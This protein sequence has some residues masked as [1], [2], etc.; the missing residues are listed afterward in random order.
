MH[1]RNHR[2]LLGVTGLTLITA[3][4]LPL[5]AGAADT[6]DK[7]EE[8]VVVGSRIRRDTFNSPSPVQVITRDDTAAAGFSST[9]D[10]LA[11]HRHHLRRL[12]DQQCVRRLRHRRWT[13]REYHFLRGLGASRTLVIINGRRVA[14]AGTRGA[15][16]SADLNV[17][18]SAMVDHIEV[19]R[20]GRILDLRFRRGSRRGERG[21]HE[22]TCATSP[23]RWSTRG[24]STTVA[25]KRVYRWSA[26]SPASAGSSPARPSFA[27]RSDLTL[28]QRDWTR[29]KPGPAARCGH[30]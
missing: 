8:I 30:R 11:V 7:L 13:R 6:D 20:D 9:T 26:A 22:E 5:G 1:E 3:S 27:D 18:P 4:V 10:V 16:G 12:A 28:G 23:P 21:D 24:R 25:R 2:R 15:V 29:C 14:P 17:L 19:L